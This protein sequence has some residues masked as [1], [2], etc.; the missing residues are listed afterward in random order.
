M[1][2]LQDTKLVLVFVG[3]VS[4]VFLDGQ[5]AG[6]QFAQRRF[7]GFGSNTGAK[8]GTTLF[9]IQ[10]MAVLCHLQ[11]LAAADE[12]PQ[13]HYRYVIKLRFKICQEAPRVLKLLGADSTRASPV[14]RYAAVHPGV[15][16]CYKNKT[17]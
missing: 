2:G 14:C 16:V 5:K 7:K 17:A 13:T 6:L 9:A 8:C 1:T 3:I 15:Q 11:C 12:R 10:N 4:P